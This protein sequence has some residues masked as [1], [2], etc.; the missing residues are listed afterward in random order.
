MNAYSVANEA[1]QSN[2]GL[3]PWFTALL[4]SLP[5]CLA[6][7]L[8]H[9]A[10]PPSG[11]S[12]RAKALIEA[13]PA[14]QRGKLEQPFTDDVR[15]DWH[16]VPRSRAGLAWNDLGARQRD[17][18]T[19]LL[20][21]A[22]TDAGLDKVRAIMALEIVLRELET[23]G[24]SRDAGNYA[25]ALYGVPSASGPWAFRIEGHHLSL[26]FTL[27]GDRFIATL[28]QFM[29]A[30]PALVPKDVVAP[31]GGQRAP[32]KGSRVLGVEED[33]GRQLLTSLS[34][35][36]RKVAV[37]DPRPYGDIVTRNAKKLDP[38]QPAGVKFTDL[39]A[40]QQAQLLKLVS[41]FADHLQ[42][43]LAEARLARVRSGGLDSIRFAWAGSSAV[44]EP[45]YFRIQ[46]AT[47][48]IE[49]DN[50][51]GNHIHSVWRDFAGDFGRDVL[52][53]HYSSAGRPGH[54]HP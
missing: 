27:E 5:L 45:Y 9:A 52:Q 36:Q 10:E 6:S 40:A 25:I 42:P 1:L 48:L 12:A 44:G 51:G 37:I 16:Y 17:A 14:E 30:N 19:A 3:G 32:A 26:H 50:S 41:A 4:L 49:F 46:G 53:E 35:A 38:L 29:G 54:S 18:A 15:S 31:E 21:S 23:F 43:E 13:T 20:K 22:L 47:F 11:A 2:G 8:S 39:T 24:R 7:V 33:R 28:P 34:E